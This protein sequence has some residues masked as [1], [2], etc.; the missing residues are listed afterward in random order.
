MNVTI[1]EFLANTRALIDADEIAPGQWAPDSMLLVWLNYGLIKLWRK[2][3]RAGRVQPQYQSVTYPAASTITIGGDKRFNG[4]DLYNEPLVIYGVS[5]VTD[6][7]PR[8]L[9]QAQS[10]FGPIPY[11]VQGGQNSTTG[12]AQTWSVVHSAENA[13]NGFGKYVISLY[14][15]PT[16][17]TY[18]VQWLEKPSHLGQPAD[19]GVL[20]I[21]IPAGLEEY[22]ILY[23][24]QRAFTRA[25]AAPPSISRM[26]QEVEADLD[27]AAEQLL[28]G[29][30]PRVINTDRELRG[31][32][33]R[34]QDGVG[35]RWDPG[36]WWWAP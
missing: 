33:R 29:S 14:P 24:A 36:S 18:Q 32:H 9:R 35:T 31:W 7:G 20:S 23:A 5:E 30:A 1:D 17:G 11:A 27:T 3:A 6:Q 2:M 19:G 16:S 22:P 26:M 10:G 28:S 15:V 34:G 12:P 8:V 4:T 13:G 25:G 21:D